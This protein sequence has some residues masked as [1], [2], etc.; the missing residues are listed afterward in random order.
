VVLLDHRLELRRGT[1][2]TSAAS[3]GQVGRRAARR[4]VAV[5][6]PGAADL[7][8]QVED[9]LPLAEG[10]QER[11]ERAQ[12][13]AVGPHADQVAGDAVQLGDD[14]AQMPGLLGIFMP[15]QLLDASDQPRFMFIAAR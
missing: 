6:Q 5:G 14:H 8:E 13:E 4:D 7:L 15:Q 1:P 11:A 3:P 2:R 12:V 10:V 9:L